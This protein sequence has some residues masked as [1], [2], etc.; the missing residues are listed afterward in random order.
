MRG[1]ISLD[2]NEEPAGCQLQVVGTSVPQRSGVSAEDGCPRYVCCQRP[3]TRAVPPAGLPRTTTAPSIR[4]RP[5]GH[6]R[7]PRA[8][9]APGSGPA[10]PL[11]NPGP[12]LSNA[13][14]PASA[15]RSG[16][17]DAGP[18]GSH[19]SPGLS[20]ASRP[21]RPGRVESRSRQGRPECRSL[22]DPCGAGPGRAGPDRRQPREPLG[23]A[24]PGE[25]AG[26]VCT[27]GGTE[28]VSAAR[29]AGITPWWPSRGADEREA[30]WQGGEEPG[31]GKGS[32]AARSG[33]QRGGRAATMGR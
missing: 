16:P 24:G 10:E 11:R 23:S 29:R 1:P 28:R 19:R 4:A 22:S 5:T 3:S 20:L 8:A 21:C 30:A 6:G 31:R 18:D 12:G 25:A 7:R 32:A 17:A 9:V 15:P 13:G 14:A 27:A 2:T 33:A 26:G